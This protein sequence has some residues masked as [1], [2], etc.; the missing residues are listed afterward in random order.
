MESIIG[1]KR[2]TVKLASFSH[3][4]SKLF[5]VE[6]ERLSLLLKDLYLDIQHVGSTSITGCCAKPIIDISIKVFDFSQIET[7]KEKMKERYIYKG[8]AGIPGRH[9]FVKGGENNRTHYIHII[10]EGSKLWDNH[11]YFRDYLNLNKDQVEKYSKLKMS[12]LD[13]YSED[14]AGYSKEKSSFIETTI[15]RAK[16]YFE[17]I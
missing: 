6:K 11:I 4:W 3:E 9:F 8:D 13:N 15:H 5:E 1:L 12:L 16:E 17:K 14:R 2:G 7:I 10:P